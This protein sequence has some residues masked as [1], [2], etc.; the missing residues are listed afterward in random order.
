MNKKNIRRII[1]TTN[2]VESKELGENCLNIPSLEF[3]SESVQEYDE[4]GN[5]LIEHQR[6]FADGVEKIDK[7]IHFYNDEGKLLKSYLFNSDTFLPH[8]VTFIYYEHGNLT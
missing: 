3:S 1:E 8:V 4:K 5:L 6:Y 7:R 2:N